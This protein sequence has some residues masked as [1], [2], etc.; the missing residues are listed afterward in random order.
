M[1]KEEILDLLDQLANIT[2]ESNDTAKRLQNERTVM[3]S[4]Y[5]DVTYSLALRAHE[6]SLQISS[7]IDDCV[8]P[9]TP[10]D[11]LG[12]RVQFMCQN[13]LNEYR[14]R[15]SPQSVAEGRVKYYD[16]FVTY[17]NP[18]QYLGDT[19]RLL[20]SLHDAEVSRLI[21]FLS[22]MWYY[23]SQIEKIVRNNIDLIIQPTAVNKMAY[24]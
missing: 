21:R 8:L 24:L 4:D 13:I 10:E 20:R 3:L 15:S 14:D 16:D 7:L 9:I 1:I 22:Y 5:H 2:A 18:T 12:S 17:S 6:L 23:G 11:S 19:T